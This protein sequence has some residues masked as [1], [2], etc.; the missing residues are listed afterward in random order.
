MDLRLPYF[1]SKINLH[2]HMICWTK[3]VLM[4]FSTK[5][6]GDL[7]YVGMWATWISV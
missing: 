3:G 7:G 5:D 6:E 4:G 1:Q 2:Q